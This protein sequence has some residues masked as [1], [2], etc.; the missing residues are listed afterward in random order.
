VENNRSTVPT[1]YN[2][3]VLAPRSIIEVLSP[4]SIIE[5]LAPRSIIEVLS[6]R[7]I[8]EVLIIDRGENTSIL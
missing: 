2:I 3:E 8:I 1:V 7:S 5:V 6:P 4:W